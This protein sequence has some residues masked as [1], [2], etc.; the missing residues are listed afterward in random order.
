MLY[1]AQMWQV[2]SIFLPKDFETW[3]VVLVAHSS[4]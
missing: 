4:W 1:C 3:L 2:P